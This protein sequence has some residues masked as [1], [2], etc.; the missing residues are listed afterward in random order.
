MIVYN[1]DYF[2]CSQHC[3]WQSNQSCKQKKFI[4]DLVPLYVLEMQTQ[5]AEVLLCLTAW[6]ILK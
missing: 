1:V 5:R 6:C 3:D 2:Y 4:I